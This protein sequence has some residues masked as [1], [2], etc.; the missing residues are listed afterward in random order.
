MQIKE[1]EFNKDRKHVGTTLYDLNK[2]NKE[3]QN[4]YKIYQKE[5]NSDFLFSGNVEHG[6]G[7]SRNIKFED[8]E[9]IDGQYILKRESTT[10]DQYN[11]E[12]RSIESY[13]YFNSKGQLIKIEEYGINENFIKDY[14]YDQDGDLIETKVDNFTM[15]FQYLHAKFTYGQIFNS[16]LN[17]NQKVLKYCEYDDGKKQD[18]FSYSQ[19]GDL[20]VL[21]K[22]EKN[23][24]RIHIWEE[25]N[26][27]VY[28]ENGN[29]ISKDIYYDGNFNKCF[30]REYGDFSQDIPVK[31]DEDDFSN[32]PF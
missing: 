21:T 31:E 28:D 26:L 6:N 7:F 23:K 22:I 24:N 9:L 1:L 30:K 2:E 4:E 12:L 10:Y 5:G 20:L 13:S 3:I 18:I 27:Y 11:S 25:K 8:A 16:K 14:K 19:F 15:E 32:L 17:R 29:W